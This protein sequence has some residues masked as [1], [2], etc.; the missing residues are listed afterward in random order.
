MTRIC[1][2][3]NLTFYFFVTTATLRTAFS[4]LIVIFN[5]LN[6]NPL[7]TNVAGQA[8]FLFT[9]IKYSILDNNYFCS[10]IKSKI[11]LNK[12]FFNQFHIFNALVYDIAFF[13][14]ICSTQR[15]ARLKK[16]STVMG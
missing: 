5:I 16:C 15:E 12:I 2:F 10:L 3:P 4:S 1:F 8:T 14:K 13:N 11:P 7:N 9:R 6:S